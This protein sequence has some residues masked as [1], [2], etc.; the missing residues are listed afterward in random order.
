MTLEAERE[1][2]AASKESG[3]TRS[4]TR[5][6]GRPSP[7]IPGGS[8]ALPA[9]GSTLWPPELGEN[10]VPSLEPPEYGALSGSLRT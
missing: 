4:W 8:A 2:L 9:L 3:A 1:G 6:E 5:Q 10:K 7:S